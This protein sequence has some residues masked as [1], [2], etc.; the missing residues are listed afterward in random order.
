MRILGVDPG[1]ATVGFAVLD[2]EGRK[3]RPI[4]YGIVESPPKT[5]MHVRLKMIYEDMC[6]I[7]ERYKP[8]CMAIEELFFNDNAKTA[9]MVGQARGVLLLSGANNGLSV[10][11]YTPLQVKQAVTGYGRADKKQVQYMVKTILKLAETPKP[12]D[13]A[14]AIA[15]AICHGY[16]SNSKRVNLK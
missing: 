12:D 14:D 8:E 9:I 6:Y 1:L 7:I 16:A 10:Y 4:E 13:T 15:I 11:E 3:Y 5:D 2:Y